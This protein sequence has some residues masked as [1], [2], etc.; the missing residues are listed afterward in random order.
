MNSREE[1][2]RKRIKEIESIL[3]NNSDITDDDLAAALI[4]NFFISK[5]VALEEIHAVRLYLDNSKGGDKHGKKQKD[6]H[7][8]SSEEIGRAE[9]ESTSGDL[10]PES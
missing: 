6:E 3:I 10:L 7:G 8:K 2:K 1:K 5:R 4:V 9:G